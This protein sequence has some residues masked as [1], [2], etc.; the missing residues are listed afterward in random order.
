M[1]R[2]ETLNLHKDQR[3][4]LGQALCPLRDVTFGL[5][6]C[7]VRSIDGFMCT[8]RLRPLD[9]RRIITLMDGAYR[10]KIAVK[11]IEPTGTVWWNGKEIATDSEEYEL[12]LERM[13]RARFRGDEEALVAL[14]RSRGLKL[15]HKRPSHASQ[16]SLVPARLY[17]KLLTKFRSELLR[18][19]TIA[20]VAR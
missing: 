3:N 13:L 5:N 11:D 20:P 16:L 2:K 4:K 14:K 15:V 12:L 8:L 1:S 9:K 7:I 10:A 19:G 17:C 6:N 18:T